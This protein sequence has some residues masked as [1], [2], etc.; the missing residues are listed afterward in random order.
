M[1][2]DWLLARSFEFFTWKTNAISMPFPLR[3]VLFSFRLVRSRSSALL[4]RIHCENS[5]ARS[6]L[7]KMQL[8]N[9]KRRLFSNEIP[10]VAWILQSEDGPVSFV[11]A[12]R[13]KCNAAKFFFLHF[14]FAFNSWLVKFEWMK[15]ISGLRDSDGRLVGVQ[16]EISRK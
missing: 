10:A 13:S 12:T 1:R 15:Q 5:L 16:S 2:G 14:F 6:P 11:N 7:P 4:L 9:W 3:F 8:L